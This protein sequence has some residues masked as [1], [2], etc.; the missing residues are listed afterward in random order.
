MARIS[1]ADDEA[2]ADAYDFSRFRRVVD[3]GGGRGG[4]L[5][6]IL[7]RNPGVESVLFDRPQVIDAP[8]RLQETGQL[9]RCQ[10]VG[11]DFL[12]SVP[13]GAE[14]Y[15][16]KGVLQDFDDEACQTVLV[17]CRNAVI[18]D[19]RSGALATVQRGRATSE[20]F[21]GHSHDGLIRRPST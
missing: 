10:C 20:Y 19:G 3:V 13:E 18:R 2:V 7:K 14:C 8:I 9:G 17:N 15:I 6:Q 5:A 21:H 11:G 4:L 12:Q 16:I 1:D